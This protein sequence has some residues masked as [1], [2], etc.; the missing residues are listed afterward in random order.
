MSTTGVRFAA[1]LL[2]IGVGIQ[3]PLNHGP[4]T[5]AA[6]TQD[7]VRT[8]SFDSRYVAQ[9]YSNDAVAGFGVDV[10][11]LSTLST[12]LIEPSTRLRNAAQGVLLLVGSTILGQAFSLAFHEYGHGTRAAAAGFEPRYGF[13]TIS[14]DAQ[15]DAALLAPPEYKSFLPYFLGSFFTQNGYTL[16]TPDDTRFPPLTQEELVETGWN[17][18]LAAGGL[19]NEMLLAERIEDEMYRNGGHI[20]F[21]TTYINSKLSASQYDLVGPFGDVGNTVT[22]YQAMGFDIDQDRIDSASRASFFLSSLSYQLI[23]QTVRMFTGASIRFT[24]WEPGGVQL[25][26]TSFFMTRSGLS[27]RVRTGYR[28]G[29]WQFPLAV[30][31]VF[32]GDKRTEVSIGAE[33]GLERMHVRARATVGEGIGVALGAGYRIR[34]G[35]DLSAGYALYDSRNLLGERL[36]P[37][38]ENGSRYHDLFLRASFAY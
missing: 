11:N 23:Y 8:F 6:Q 20:G 16:A 21:I 22:N 13:G 10:L 36:I 14:T 19:N 38:L 27:Y 5:L 4:A 15:V 12:Q 3:A 29:D 9:T 2:V 1:R 25:P 24:A 7:P 34:D 35:V 37:S 33:R 28:T 26:N 31:R 17:V 32:E 18:L 30:E